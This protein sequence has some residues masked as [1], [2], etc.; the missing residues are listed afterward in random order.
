M[1]LTNLETGKPVVLPFTGAKKDLTVVDNGD[2]TITIRTAVTG[3]PEEVGF[4]TAPWRSSMS[5][6]SCS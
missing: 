1:S 2:G 3:V 5:G 4:R 6:A